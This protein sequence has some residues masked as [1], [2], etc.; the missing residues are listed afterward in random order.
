MRDLSRVVIE[1]AVALRTI[2]AVTHRDVNV[3]R[4]IYLADELIGLDAVAV[5][6][7]R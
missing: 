5:A 2:R 1:P 4:R 6:I 7:C 3:G